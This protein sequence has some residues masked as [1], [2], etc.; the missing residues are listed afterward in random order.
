[1][2]RRT[3]SF[4]IFQDKDGSVCPAKQPSFEELNF[5]D[6]DESQLDST[7]ELDTDISDEASENDDY[8]NSSP[9]IEESDSDVFQLS[10]SDN[11]DVNSSSSGE[12]VWECSDVSSSD[13]E[14]VKE[15]STVTNMVYGVSLFLNV[16]NLYVIKFQ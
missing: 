12:E 2:S 15:Q 6:Q 10:E 13:D 7:F 9:N 4:S 16:F 3:C 8:I 1:M 14:E 11:G 5:S